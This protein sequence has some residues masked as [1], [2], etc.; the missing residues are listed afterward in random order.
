MKYQNW[1]INIIQYITHLNPGCFPLKW[2]D[3]VTMVLS[4][5]KIQVNFSF[6]SGQNC[7]PL[8]KC[9]I[10]KFGT[11]LNNLINLTGL[12]TLMKNTPCSVSNTSYFY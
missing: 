9:Q 10:H 8:S 11:P 4:D 7:P 6:K 2:S 1:N 12:T 3:H 5:G